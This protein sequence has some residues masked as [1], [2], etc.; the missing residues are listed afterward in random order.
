MFLYLDPR[1]KIGPIRTEFERQIRANPLWDERVQA[2]QV[3]DTQRDA[4]EVPL[5]MS[6][7]DSSRF[8]IYGATSAKA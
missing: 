7:D 5:L 8:S 4:K 1:A 6:A 3:T 2:V